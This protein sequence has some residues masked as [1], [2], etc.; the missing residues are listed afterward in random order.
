MLGTV[1]VAC[2]SALTEVICLLLLV[3]VIMLSNPF[4]AGGCECNSF[5]W[6]ICSCQ[7][8]NQHCYK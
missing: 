6:R 5:T 3:V 1:H 2:A 7:S 4:Y 8:R